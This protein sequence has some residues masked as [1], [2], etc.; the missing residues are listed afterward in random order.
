MILVGNS[1]ASEI[2]VA[3]KQR[4]CALVGVESRLYHLPDNVTQEQLLKTIYA[5]NKDTAIH[6]ILVQM[7]LP[8]HIHAWDVLQAVNPLKDVDGLHQDNLGLLFASEPRFIPCTPKGCLAILSRITD[9][10]GKSVTV[11][12]RS[13]LVGRPMAALLLKN[14]ATVTTAHRHTVD[15]VTVT[16]NADILVV[17]AGKP[18]LI[19]KNHVKPGAIILDVGINRMTD[20]EGRDKIV[21]DVI[22]DEVAP[23]CQYITPVPGGIGPMTV[24]SLMD[25]VVK[26]AKMSIETHSNL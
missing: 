24:A 23:L 12:G 25:N 5:L 15:L 22:F 4:A 10:K 8:P 9:I 2:Y 16:R 19:T 6:G 21:G 13:I 20:H 14:N 3:H 7:P 1:P 17:A 18:G 26:A 11:V